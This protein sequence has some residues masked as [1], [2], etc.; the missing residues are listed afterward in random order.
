MR[1]LSSSGFVV[2]Y[3]VYGYEISPRG[4]MRPSALS[5]FAQQCAEDELAL[6]A[7]QGVPT[8]GLQWVVRR[9][10]VGGW[11]NMPDIETVRAV[12]RITGAGTCWLESRTEFED[13]ERPLGASVRTFWVQLDCET[14]KP[15]PI[16]PLFAELCRAAGGTQD[17]M[18]R[19]EIGPQPAYSHSEEIRVREADYDALG[20]VNNSMYLDLVERLTAD[21][22]QVSLEYDSPIGWGTTAVRL[23]SVDGDGGTGFVIEP[24]TG[25]RPYCHGSTS[26]GRGPTRESKGER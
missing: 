10:V 2:D 5:R 1:E 23:R 18:W 21:A 4:Y 15:T 25:H 20:H 14:G 22:E 13:G 17:L 8:I 16:A 11:R 9:N 6:L 3:K 19:S 12:R 26:T 24:V 7:E